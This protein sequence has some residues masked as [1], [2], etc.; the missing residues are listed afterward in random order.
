MGKATAPLLLSPMKQMP[1]LLQALLIPQGLSSQ[2]STG[3]RW[4][5]MPQGSLAT[6]SVWGGQ[7]QLDTTG[8]WT[9]LVGSED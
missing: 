8:P 5:K 1:H 2:I 3:T 4:H 9:P 6:R 7:D